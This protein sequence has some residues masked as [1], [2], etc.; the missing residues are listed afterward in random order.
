MLK[1]LR[2]KKLLPLGRQLFRPEL[3]ACSRFG[4]CAMG[5]LQSSD[6]AYLARMT[7]QAYLANLYLNLPGK[8][9]ST[10]IYQLGAA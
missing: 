9:S 6:L 8:D 1:I 5:T 2:D 4:T 3:F 10:C 7:L